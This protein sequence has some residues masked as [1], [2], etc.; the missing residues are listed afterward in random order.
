[1][2]AKFNIPGRLPGLNEIIAK[3][4]RNRWAGSKQK[5][6]VTAECAYWIRIYKVP[7]FLSPVIVRFKWIEPNA[8]RDRDN[9]Q[10]GSK[11]ILD[12]LQAV[13]VIVNDS[14]KWVL[15]VQH[16]TS[17]V[18]KNNPRVEVIISDASGH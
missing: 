12:A 10:S 16:D 6:D 9:V 4:N 2:I 15:D 14:R 5:K 8:R 3:I 1:M 11:F 13:G 18:D 17:E 7:A